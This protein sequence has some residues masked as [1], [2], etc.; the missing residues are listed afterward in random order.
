MLAV[1]NTLTMAASVRL[2][3]GFSACFCQHFGVA[4]P[5]ASVNLP[6]SLS[7]HRQHFPGLSNI[8]TEA[9]AY[10]GGILQ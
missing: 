10:A 2:D 9:L 6:S 3:G 7:I 8:A 4:A 5:L 1:T